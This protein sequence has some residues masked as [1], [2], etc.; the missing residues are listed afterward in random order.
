VLATAMAR[1]RRRWKPWYVHTTLAFDRPTT[2]CDRAVTAAAHDLL[3]QAGVLFAPVK[4][5]GRRSYPP[6]DLR[7]DHTR[8]R[9]VN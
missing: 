1:F 6:Y 3:L 5:L 8:T 9:T 7:C 2:R 4:E